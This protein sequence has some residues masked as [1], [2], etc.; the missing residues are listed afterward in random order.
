VSK[1]H[2]ECNQVVVYGAGDHAKAVLATIEAEGKYEAIGLLDDNEARRGSIVYGYQVL[3]GREHLMD[4]RS[5]GISRAIVAVGDNF[6]RAELAHLLGESGFQL[7]RAI[8]PTATI[9]C[10]SHIGEGSMLLGN[11]WVGADVTIGKS[12]IVSVG[13]VVGHDCVV[14][15]YAQLCPAVSLGGHVVIGDYSFIGI[16]ATVL[17]RVTVGRQVVVG[18]NTAVINDLPDY[19]TA[20]GVPVRI[21]KRRTMQ[22]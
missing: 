22:V 9:L 6:K 14:G 4:L 20:V 18:A 7:V 13:V 10:D 19:V 11:V 5:Q 15:A 2:R 8:H 16:G 17:P 1:V 21:V 3:G 12:A